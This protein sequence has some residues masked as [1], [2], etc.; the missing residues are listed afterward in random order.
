MIS[1]LFPDRD[2]KAF[3]FDFDGTVADTMPP[4][5]EA[6]NRALESHGL[7]LSPEL[8]RTWAGRPTREIVGLLNDRHGTQLSVDE[9]AKTKETHYLTLLDRV[10]AILPVLEVIRRYHGH[11]PMAIV[12]GSRRRPI[13][14]TLHHL[15]LSHYFDL[16]VCAEDY[17]H[18]KPNPDCFLQ[19]A[20][21]LGVSPHECLVFEDAPL[22]IEAAHRA[23]M[24][25]LQ[26][27]ETPEGGHLLKKV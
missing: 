16:I 25:C 8:H 7:D 24:E 19:A 17:K 1:Q 14:T 15:G 21:G 5:L 18:G 22:G 27:I 13:E 6:W 23:N 10:K 9:I 3:L 11:L 12:S 4:H 2:F 26:V 20:A